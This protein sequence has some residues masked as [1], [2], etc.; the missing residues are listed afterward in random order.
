MDSNTLSQQFFSSSLV[1]SSL[2]FQG[3]TTSLQASSNMVTPTAG[4]TGFDR[5]NPQSESTE[6]SLNATLTRLRQNLSVSSSEQSIGINISLKSMS[7]LYKLDE[8]TD[9]P[10]NYADPELAKDFK[11]IIRLLAKDE[12]EY[13]ELE[14]R[15][16]KLMDGI[17]GAV[18][19]V[20]ADSSGDTNVNEEFE[21]SVS[22]GFSITINLQIEAGSESI[23]RVK[24]Q[25]LVDVQAADPLIIDLD[26]D[27]I[28]ISEVD[29]GALFDITGSGQ[30][31]L[32]SSVGPD[33]GLLALDRNSNGIIDSGLE[34]FGDQ[35]G[36]ADG[37]AELANY[38]SDANGV[39]NSSDS[40]YNKLRIYRDINQDGISQQNELS[41]LEEMKIASIDLSFSRIND[42]INGNRLI[43]KGNCTLEDGSKR[44]MCDALLNYVA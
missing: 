25:A 24:L 27:G 1:S 40:V 43:Y 34:L 12:K 38:D 9:S 36:A 26:G 14:S 18:K 37:F 39:I 33:D 22:V 3:L 10:D 4:V 32:V 16:D 44:T 2:D 41:S 28:E 42:F 8:K 21:H 5:T 13:K 7:S 23:H 17:S 20:N 35:H 6:F 11:L 31:H 30:K 15:F 19:N 29:Q